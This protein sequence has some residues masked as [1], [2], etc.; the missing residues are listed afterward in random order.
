MGIGGLGRA[1][2]FSFLFV[3]EALYPLSYAPACSPF[4]W[5]VVEELVEQTGFEPAA[6]CVQN[7]RSAN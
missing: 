1:R 5:G 2:T 3:G 7:R 4:F 6:S